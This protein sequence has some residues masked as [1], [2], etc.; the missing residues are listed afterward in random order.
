MSDEKAIVCNVVGCEYEASDKCA[1]C[2]A[3][4]CPEHDDAGVCS[5][6]I[7]CPTCDGD[8]WIPQTPAP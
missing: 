4:L 6:C 7:E 3:P 1:Q 5:H 8:G 2:E